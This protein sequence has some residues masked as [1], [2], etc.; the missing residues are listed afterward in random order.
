MNIG[1]R[2]KP[3]LA[4]RKMDFP[5]EEGVHPVSNLPT[6]GNILGIG[7]F[8]YDVESVHVSE[9]PFLPGHD[10]WRPLVKKAGIHAQTLFD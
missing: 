7:A 6:I 3:E 4:L 8:P 9:F 2:F 1:F 5:F 10:S